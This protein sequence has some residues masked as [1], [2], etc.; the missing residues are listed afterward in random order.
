MTGSA[1]PVPGPGI[2]LIT[3]IDHGRS[4]ASAG[5]LVLGGVTGDP[6]D[7]QARREEEL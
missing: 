7:H 4:S 1:R 6:G 2:A 5:A 3:G